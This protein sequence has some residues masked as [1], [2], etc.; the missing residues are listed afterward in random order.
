MENQHSVQG[1][2]FTLDVKTKQWTPYQ[3]PG[4]RDLDG[5]DLSWFI[6]KKNRNYKLE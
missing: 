3:I 5:W 4:D 1:R 6:V 2:L